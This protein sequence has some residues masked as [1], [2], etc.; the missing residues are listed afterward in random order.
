MKLPP[1]ISIKTP[2]EVMKIF[3]FF[4]K[5]TKPTEKKN[6]GKLYAQASSPKINEILKIKEIFPKL[7]TNRIDN[8]YKIINGGNKPKPKLNMTTKE[9]FRKQV[10]IPM[11]NNNKAKYMELS[12]VY[13]TNLNRA[14][15][16]IKSDI[17]ADFIYIKQIGITIVTHKVASSLN[18]QTIKKYTKNVNYIDTNEIDILYLL[19]LKFYLKIIGILYLVKNTNILI[20]SDIVKKIIKSNH[21]FNTITVA[22]KPYII[23]VSSKLDIWNVQSDNKIKELINKCFNIGS[24][25]ATI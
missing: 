18:I 12:S 7:L 25:I 11:N 14:L 16:N 15:K 1:L 22:S 21:I 23:K 24:H 6:I 2:K 17:M 3:K 5:D 8:I 13:I 4:K 19:Q 9:P 20:S 10:I